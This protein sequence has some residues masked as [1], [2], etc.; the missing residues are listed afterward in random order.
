[1]APTTSTMTPLGTEAPDFALYDTENN[2]V[3]R[4][5]FRGAKA[6]LVVFMSNYCPYAKHV[7]SHLVSLAKEYQE[8]GVA[9]IGINANDCDNYPDETPSRMAEDATD[10]GYT[11]PY[12]FDHA[13]DV[14]KAYKAACSPDF[15]LFDTNF[16]LV[17]RGQMDDSRPGNGKI[18]DGKDLRDA[19]DAVLEG[20]VVSG[21]QKPGMGCNIKWKVG[22]E[23]EYFEG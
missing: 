17:Y 18:T 4:D 21:V 22:N 14:A 16:K 12:L 8:K 10:Y 20:K 1:M 19:L 15:F 7:R 6:L 3:K 9:V 5:D 13:Q 2:L 11:F 23:P